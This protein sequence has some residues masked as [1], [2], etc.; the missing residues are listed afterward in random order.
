MRL[1]EL[2]NYGK[3]ERE[4]CWAVRFGWLTVYYSYKTPVAFSVRKGREKRTCLS[5]NVWSRTTGKHLNYIRNQYDLTDGDQ[6]DVPNGE[7]EFLLK[8]VSSLIPALSDELAD[9]IFAMMGDK[10]AAE[11]V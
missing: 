3:N 4:P 8:R 11:R 6:Y 2:F 5:A 7:F 10:D 9:E 1:P